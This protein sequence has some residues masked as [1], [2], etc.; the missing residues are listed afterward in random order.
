MY[1]E[2]E[3]ARNRMLADQDAHLKESRAR[4]EAL[5]QEAKV[6]IQAEADAAKRSL[7]DSSG[8][9]ADQISD[10]VLTRRAS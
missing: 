2:Q 10:A 9:L 1:R 4:V 3:Q 7:T 6:S 5:I 8:I